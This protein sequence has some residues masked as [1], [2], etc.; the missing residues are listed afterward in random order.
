MNMIKQILS[1]Y[2]KLFVG[3]AKVL[4]LLAFCLLTGFALVWPLWYFAV[5]QPV[6]Y[7]RTL[8][9]LLLCAVVV[10]AVRKKRFFVKALVLVLG[11][12]GFVWAILA[13]AKVLAALAVLLTLLIYGI[14]AYGTKKTNA[15]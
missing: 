15:T 10:F 11:T 5:N 12:V 8:L 9:V 7:T 2:R 6:L 3:V 1:G 14:L 4:A 13:G